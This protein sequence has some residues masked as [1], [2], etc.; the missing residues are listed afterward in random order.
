MIIR[1]TDQGLVYLH[2]ALASLSVRGQTV[3]ALGFVVSVTRTQL[4]RFSV[5]AAREKHVKE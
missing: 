1:K 4:C 3:N 5:K 2:Q